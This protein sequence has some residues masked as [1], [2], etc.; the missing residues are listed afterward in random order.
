[1]S[2]TRNSIILTILKRFLFGKMSYVLRGTLCFIKLAVV[3]FISLLL[4][5]NA[6]YII[7]VVVVHHYVYF[8]WLTSQSTWTISV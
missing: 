7:V 5:R 4:Y 3:A 1:M 6:C 2:Y 8:S